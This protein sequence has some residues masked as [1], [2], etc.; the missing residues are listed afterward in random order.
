MVEGEVGVAAMIEEMQVLHEHHC[1]D[2]APFWTE[3]ACLV[4]RGSKQGFHEL[5]PRSCVE[6]KGLLE[7]L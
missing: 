4:A 5:G 3:Q 1:G 7:A 6:M 2:F